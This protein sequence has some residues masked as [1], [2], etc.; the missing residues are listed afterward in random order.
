M[1]IKKTMEIRIEDVQYEFIVD[2]VDLNDYDLV[3]IQD[4]R[5][6]SIRGAKEEIFRL[7]SHRLLHKLGLYDF[8]I[9][10][11]KDDRLD[12]ARYFPLLDAY[13]DDR[14]KEMIDV[15]EVSNFSTIEDA[16]E[17]LQKILKVIREE[18]EIFAEAEA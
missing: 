7:L 14:D 1:T 11:T 8:A 15:E 3:V 6:Y 17:H 4:L 9:V 12:V 13:Y 2:H 5:R 10:Q 18:E 16:K